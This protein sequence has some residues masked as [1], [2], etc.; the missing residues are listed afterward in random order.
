LH[1][2]NQPSGGHSG[3]QAGGSDRSYRFD[4]EQIK[5]DLSVELPVYPF[6]N[7][8]GHGTTDP[9]KHFFNPQMEI[10]PEELRVKYY[11]ARLQGVEQQ[12]VGWQPN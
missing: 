10:S 4:V 6:S 3:G 1:T 2:G 7:Y 9:P 8:A 12:A 5:N 11:L